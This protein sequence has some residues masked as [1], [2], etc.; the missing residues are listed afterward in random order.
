MDLAS[1]DSYKASSVANSV[2]A[3]SID[4]DGANN[5]AGSYDPVTE[6]EDFSK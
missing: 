3:T 4:L 1:G 5:K 6:D 2:D